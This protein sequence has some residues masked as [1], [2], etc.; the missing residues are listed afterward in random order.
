LREAVETPCCHTAFCEECITTHLVEHDFECPQ[1]ES[2]VAS[3][4]RLQPDEEAR[5]RVREYQMGK[6]ED[7]ARAVKAESGA[8]AEASAG[9]TDETKREAEEVKVRPNWVNVVVFVLRLQSEPEEGALSPNPG[10]PST[11]A[12]RPAPSAANNAAPAPP[13]VKPILDPVKMREMLNPQVMNIYMT[14][15]S[16]RLDFCRLPEVARALPE[17]ELTC[18]WR[19]CFKIPHYPRKPKPSSKR[20]SNSYKPA[21]CLCVRCRCSVFSMVHPAAIQEDR[22]E[23]EC[24]GCRAVW[25]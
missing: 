22:R 1:C 18:R 4:D 17:Y 11:S 8:G 3:L 14:Q 2:K 15:V 7:A 10:E 13:E 5:E 6:E 19:K 20:N 16:S 25:A 23:T 9:E 21:S 12:A 24:K